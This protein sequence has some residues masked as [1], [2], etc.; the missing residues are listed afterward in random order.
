MMLLAWTGESDCIVFM[1]FGSFRYV[2]I[3]QALISS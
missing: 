2:S 1:L 3:Y